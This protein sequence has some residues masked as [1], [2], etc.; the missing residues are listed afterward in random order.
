MKRRRNIAFCCIA[1]GSVIG[2]LV[3]LYIYYRSLVVQTS[4]SHRKVYD[5]IFVGM[6]KVD[7][8]ETLRR[9]FVECGLTEPVPAGTT[10]HFSDWWHYYLIAIDPDKDLVQRKYMG[11]RIPRFK[12]AVD[13][14]NPADQAE[15]KN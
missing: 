15:S 8:V 14:R 6:T 5:Q 12:R 9:D 1:V 4:L 7:A 2:S 3:G 10:C 13:G 11:D